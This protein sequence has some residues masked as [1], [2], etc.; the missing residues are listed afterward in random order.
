[1]EKEFGNEEK[2]LQRINIKGNM[3]KIRKMDKEFTNGQM[4]MNIMVSLL[5]IIN[6]DMEK[7]TI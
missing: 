3:R 5:M 7:C 4:A 6:M 2:N 1:M